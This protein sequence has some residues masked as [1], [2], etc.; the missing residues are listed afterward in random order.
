MD[1]VR[2][3]E[4]LS[5]P[6]DS[7]LLHSS[8]SLSTVRKRSI[9]PEIKPDHDNH[10]HKS[11]EH[12]NKR[13]KLLIKRALLK[14]FVSSVNTKINFK[15]PSLPI[16]IP[17][18]LF[19]DQGTNGTVKKLDKDE[20]LLS[21]EQSIERSQRISKRYANGSLKHDNNTDVLDGLSQNSSSSSSSSMN[22]QL[23]TTHGAH[24]KKNKTSH[25]QDKTLSKQEPSTLNSTTIVKNEQISI[26]NN[27]TPSNDLDS[28]TRTSFLSTTNTATISP[29]LS[30]QPKKEKPTAK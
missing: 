11:E 10:V 30:T 18:H 12:Q 9:S 16:A 28:K 19:L 14:S 15:R 25:V 8:E 27:T 4:T 7:S 5:E 29:M 6:V 21:E 13:K 20:Y 1:F 23:P 3:K 26:A 24:Q 17:T 22:N 2:G